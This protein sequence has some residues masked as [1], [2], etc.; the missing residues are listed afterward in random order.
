MAAVV[1][2]HRLTLATAK[3]SL[4]LSAGSSWRPGAGEVSFLWVRRRQVVVGFAPVVAIFGVH[5][6]DGFFI[7]DSSC[8]ICGTC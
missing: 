2:I 1:Q 3:R 4:A 5:I 7:T 6:N 8:K